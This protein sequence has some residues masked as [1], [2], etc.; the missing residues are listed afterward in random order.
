MGGYLAEPARYYPSIFSPDGLFGEYPYL[1][2]NIV[3]VVAIV[4]AVVQGAIFL[5]ETN[6]MLV[7]KARLDSMDTIVGADE[8]TPLI[9][10]DIHSQISEVD[11]DRS[12][13]RRKPQL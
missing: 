2:P 12:N 10:N 1:L 7:E 11:S 6:P 9:K 3:C 5:K 4:I 8:Q 13:L